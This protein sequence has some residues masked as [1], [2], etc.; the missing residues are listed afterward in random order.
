MSGAPTTTTIQAL[1][2]H[3]GRKR[4]DATFELRADHVYPFDHSEFVKYSFHCRCDHDQV[5][6]AATILRLVREAVAAGET[7]IRF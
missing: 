7:T 2:A 1:C 5:L 4:R 3:C 6:T